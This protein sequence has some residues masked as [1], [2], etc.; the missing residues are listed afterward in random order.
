MAILIILP[1]LIESKSVQIEIQNKLTAKFQTNIDIKSDIDISFFPRPKITIKDVDANNLTTEDGYIDINFSSIDF[2]PSIFSLFDSF[3]IKEVRFNGVNANYII[4]YEEKLPTKEEL[5]YIPSVKKDSIASKIFNFNSLDR[6]IFDLRNIGDVIFTNSKLSITDINGSTYSNYKNLY[7]KL[8]SDLDNGKIYANGSFISD[9]IPT[10]FNLDISTDAND[11]STLEVGSPILQANISG[12]FFDTKD[13]SITKSNFDGTIN[14]SISNL[15]L[16]LD[17]YFSQKSLIF[18]NINNT[19]DIKISSN[20]FIKDGIINIENINIDS[21]IIN[22]SGEIIANPNDEN[23]LIE[24]KL[25]IGYLNFDDLWLGKFQP[26]KDDYLKEAI[27]SISNNFNNLSNIDY[28]K[29]PK[30]DMSI[31]GLLPKSHINIKELKYQDQLLQ[32]VIISLSAK[33]KNQI[34]LENFELN[35]Q[36]DSK[37]QITG[38]IE[39]IGSLVKLD[40]NLNLDSSNLRNVVDLSNISIDDVKEDSLKSLKANSKILILPNTVILKEIRA[41]LDNNSIISGDLSVKEGTDILNANYNLNFNQL[42]LEDYFSNNYFNKFIKGNSFLKNFIG[43]NNIDVNH[44]I[45]LKFG[46]LSYNDFYLSNQSFDINIGRG[47]INIPLLL[48]K[49]KENNNIIKFYLDV[50]SP[51]PVLNF[52]LNSNYLSIN[53]INNNFSSDKFNS[54]FLNYF[55]DFPSLGGFDGNINID[56]KNLNLEGLKMQKF[57]LRAPFKEGIIN[58]EKA[59]AEIFGGKINVLG[60]IVLGKQK[61]LNNSFQLTEISNSALLK[62]LFNINNIDSKS[63]IS[64][65]ITSYAKNREEFYDNL[66]LKV[67]FISSGVT[68]AKYGIGNLLRKINK[69]IKIKNAEDVVLSDSSKTYFKKIT[70]NLDI[71]SSKKKRDVYISTKS[72]GLNTI[73]NGFI[74]LKSNKLN[75][76]H[77]AV[78][79]VV[80]RGR[81]PLPLR[82]ALNASGSADNLRLSPNFGQ[83]NQ[84]LKIQ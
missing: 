26:I 16:L 25:L 20:L 23:K 81:K 71:K 80:K 14:L 56:I 48:I 8:D 47:T 63:N 6:D 42:K 4:S 74:D 18:R 41:V 3:E 64:G 7:I 37:L 72:L 39:N 50:Y 60:D 69:N 52:T 12:K 11:V 29:F 66:S 38:L 75:L 44:K 21:K 79:M 61:R 57:D 54:N 31:F 43:L 19:E 32:D 35:L 9:D 84:Y 13:L 51:I 73:T 27:I 55:F 22:G 62:S 10:F 78:L 45:A 49:H 70:G 46:N 5:T 24:A 1:S 59:T 33:N 58:I 30:L 36:N 68:I 77:N 83:I 28:Q 53:N 2:I 40:G 17:K 65:V 67:N 34:E 15:K 76:N 82:F